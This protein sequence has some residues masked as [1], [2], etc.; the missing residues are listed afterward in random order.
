MVNACSTMVPRAR[1]PVSAPFERHSTSGS[2]PNL[3]PPP[4][5]PSR[6]R[7]LKAGSEPSSPHDF[8]RARVVLRGAWDVLQEESPPRSASPLSDPRPASA[9]KPK[10]VFENARYFL[11]Q[12]TSPGSAFRRSYTCPPRRVQGGLFDSCSSIAEGDASHLS[13]SQIAKLSSEDLL[14]RSIQFKPKP[15]SGSL[16]KASILSVLTTGSTK[17]KCRVPMSSSY[18]VSD[19]HEAE[20]RITFHNGGRRN[21]N[22]DGRR[23]SGLMGRRNSGLM[24]AGANESEPTSPTSLRA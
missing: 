4:V 15:A 11:A 10:S 5:S 13:Y 22:K 8:T 12:E 7:V 17:S 1:R 18:L 6:G 9:L 23:N 2:L 21:S 16:G 3:R 24:G 19:L 20:N 14:Q